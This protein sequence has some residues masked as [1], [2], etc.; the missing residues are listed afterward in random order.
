ARANLTR[1]EGKIHY[2]H[3]VAGVQVTEAAHGSPVTLRLKAAHGAVLGE[4]RVPVKI[5]SCLEGGD[6]TG[7]VDAI[8]PAIPDARQIELVIG[9]RSADTFHAGGAPQ[10]IRDVKRSGGPAVPRL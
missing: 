9:D 5:D 4:Y 6:R 10:P 8:I 3:P 1:N 7:L 2:V